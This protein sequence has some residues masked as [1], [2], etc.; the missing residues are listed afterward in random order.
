MTALLLLPRSAADLT[1]GRGPLAA[2]LGIGLGAWAWFVA[3][4]VVLGFLRGPLYGVVDPGPYDDAWGGPS[5]AGAW[6]VHA[7]VWVG[8][9]AVALGMWRALARLHAAVVEHL[10]GSRRRVWPVPVAVLLL[11]LAGGF[12]VLWTRQLG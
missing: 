1:R 11:V 9:L 10:A 4:L 3:F 12:V 5:L 8:V 6:T 7:L 2:L